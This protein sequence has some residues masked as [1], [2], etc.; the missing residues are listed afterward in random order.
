M[1]SNDQ[2]SYQIL[3]DMFFIEGRYIDRVYCNSDNGAKCVIHEPLVLLFEFTLGN[4][5]WDIIKTALRFMMDKYPGRRMVVIAPNY[6]QY[7]IDHVKSDVT[8]FIQAYQSETSGG[9]IPFPM[10]FAKN[11][12]YKS[13]EKKIYQDL[14][15]FLG[16]SMITPL[17][18]EEFL[19][20]I[21]EYFKVFSEYQQALNR[22]QACQKDV[23]AGKATQADLDAVVS[24][25]P[26]NDG[27]QL[28][29][30]IETKVGTYFGTCDMITIGDKN[31]EFS[32]FTNKNQN[33]IDIHIIDAKDEF[34]KEMA[35]I[36]NVR[37]VKKEYLDAKERLA[38]IAC[39]SAVKAKMKLGREEVEKLMD[40]L[41]KLPNPFTCPH[42]RPTAIKMSKY[43]LEKNFRR[44]Q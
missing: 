17:V 1:S 7:F 36:E 26:K 9:A 14:P 11:P 29:K 25:V 10:V 22:V 16:N 27:S 23:Q 12:F 13:A 41:L 43:D 33:L 4:E 39:K 38:R 35:E 37:Y 2:A 30:D 24:F 34:D 40:E 5:H 42:G 32:G 31:I 15:P 18:G 28:L 8:D 19:K 44:I 6:D 21:R 3:N 20:M